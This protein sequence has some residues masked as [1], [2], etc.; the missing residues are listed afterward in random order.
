MFSF[1]DFKKNQ[2]NDSLILFIFCFLITSSYIYI[3]NIYVNQIDELEKFNKQL[4]IQNENILLQLRKT[5]ITLKESIIKTPINENLIYGLNENELYY[6]KIVSVSLLVFISIGILIY[7]NSNSTF[8]SSPG[9]SSSSGPSSVNLESQSLPSIELTSTSVSNKS[10]NHVHEFND[11]LFE[12]FI[13]YDGKYDKNFY[14][15]KNILIRPVH[16]NEGHGNFV[17]FAEFSEKVY[18]V[19]GKEQFIDFI[20]SVGFF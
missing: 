15:I 11:N 19:L 7:Y 3:I 16:N 17:T 8:P 9:S 6:A 2:I 20:Y 14:L 5:T 10:I 12:Y 1:H 13:L 4:L 18:E